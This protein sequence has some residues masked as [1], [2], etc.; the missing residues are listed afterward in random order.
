[1]VFVSPDPCSDGDEE[2]RE[3]KKVKGAA[4]DLI[5]CFVSFGSGSSHC[6]MVKSIVLFVI[7]RWHGDP[8]R[9]KTLSP[10]GHPSCLPLLSPASCHPY[11]N[12]IFIDNLR[13][14]NPRNRLRGPRPMAGTLRHNPLCDL[15]CIPVHSSSRGTEIKIIKPMFATEIDAQGTFSID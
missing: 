1:M 10:R 7:Q 3:E 8:A 12:L 11:S 4:V 6:R 9:S 2:A 15:P 13:W 14:T 5:D